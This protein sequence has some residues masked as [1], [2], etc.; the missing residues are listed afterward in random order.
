MCN[1]TMGYIIGIFN[2][3]C[4]LFTVSGGCR[5]HS[6]AAAVFKTRLL[7]LVL[8]SCNA[9][10]LLVIMGGYCENKDC[11]KDGIFNQVETDLNQVYLN[12]VEML[13]NLVGDILES[14]R[15]PTRIKFE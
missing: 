9:G 10:N 4:K 12:Q 7:Q 14:G 6:E 2:D 3:Y 13:L 8:A 11:S 5:S 1:E 15:E